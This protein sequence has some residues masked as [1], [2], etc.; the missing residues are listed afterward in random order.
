MAYADDVIIM[1]RRWQD[2][3]EVF[4]SLGE[5]TNKKGLEVNKKNVIV[6]R[7]SHDENEYVKLGTCNFATVKDYTYHGA[8]LTDEN[9]LRPE[10]ENIIISINRAYY[11]LL[12]VLKSQSVLR[13]E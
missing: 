13:A 9:E 5:Q 11:T 12:P 3:K 4:T 10:T 6:S 1:G 7:N 2:V 8:I